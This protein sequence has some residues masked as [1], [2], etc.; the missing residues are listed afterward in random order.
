MCDSSDT[1]TE[2]EFKQLPPLV[3]AHACC[4][5]LLWEQVKRAVDWVCRADR[6]YPCI[7]SR[8]EFGFSWES[9][10]RQLLGYEDLP[11]SSPLVGVNLYKGSP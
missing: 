5:P 7:Y 8:L 1:T 11:P 2:G 3:T 10:T 4:R 6:Q 9:A